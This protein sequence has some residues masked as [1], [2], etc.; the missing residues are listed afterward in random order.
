MLRRVRRTPEGDAATGVVLAAFRVNGLLLAA[1]DALA[2][3]AGLTAARWQVLG[4]LELAGQPL[5]VPQIARRMGLARQSVHA[6]VAHLRDAG[7][8]ELSPNAEHRRS[9][10]VRVT[11]PGRERYRA[12]ASRQVAWADRLAHGMDRA[13]LETTARVLAELCRRLDAEPGDP[14]GTDERRPSP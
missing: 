4:A 5:T 10:L 2:G 6:T 1:G 12:L 14:T 13:E 3:E 9:P 11:P 8:V 7:L